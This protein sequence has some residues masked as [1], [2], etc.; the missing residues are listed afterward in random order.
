[1][2]RL[3]KEWNEKIPKGNF[4]EVQKQ[5]NALLTKVSVEQEWFF[6]HWSGYTAD[7]FEYKLQIF[8]RCVVIR[9]YMNIKIPIS[10]QGIEKLYY[11]IK[12]YNRNKIIY[13]LSLVKSGL[14]KHSHFYLRFPAIK[15]IFKN[16]KRPK[17]RT[18]QQV[19]K[20]VLG[21]GAKL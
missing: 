5:L 17:K 3:S 14:Y 10:F 2:V 7:Q 11:T 1:M 19:R 9:V 21:I 6:D 20:E 18:Y 16:I 15:I 8:K 13:Q 12:R 4:R